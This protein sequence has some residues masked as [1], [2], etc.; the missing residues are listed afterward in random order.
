MTDKRVIKLLEQ[1]ARGTHDPTPTRML[2]PLDN[3][4]AQEIDSWWQDYYGSNDKSLKLLARQAI[5]IIETQYVDPCPGCKP[6]IV[7]RTMLCGRLKQN[8][9]Y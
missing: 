1:I 9:T 5:A 2:P 3:K 7:C 6:G 4:A 8:V